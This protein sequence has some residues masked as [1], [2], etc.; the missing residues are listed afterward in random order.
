MTIQK[1]N[2]IDPMCAIFIFILLTITYY[3]L[4]QITLDKYREKKKR[5]MNRAPR[6]NIFAFIHT[7]HAHEG[8]RNGVRHV[9]TY[10]ISSQV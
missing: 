9:N 2:K 5:E 3:L 1:K 10:C 6:S 7:C 8:V 4:G